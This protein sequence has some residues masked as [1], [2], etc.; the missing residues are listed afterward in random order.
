[1]FL[2]FSSNKQD[3]ISDMSCISFFGLFRFTFVKQEDLYT[4]TWGID[5]ET[6]VS[7]EPTSRTRG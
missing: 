5:R 4:Y 7:T 3:F 1:M 6:R 2:A